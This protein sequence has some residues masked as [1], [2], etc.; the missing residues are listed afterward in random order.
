MEEPF[1][2]RN[3]TSPAGLVVFDIVATR[4]PFSAYNSLR[5]W[6]GPSRQRNGPTGPGWA[7]CR[8]GL[9]R[10]C[11]EDEDCVLLAW[12]FCPSARETETVFYMG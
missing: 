9:L 6:T 5:T 8:F 10:G 3:T 7:V 11:E 4:R 1:S 2:T 12:N